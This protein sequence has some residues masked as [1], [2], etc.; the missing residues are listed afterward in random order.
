MKTEELRELLERATKKL[1]YPCT[2]DEAWNDRMKAQV[3]LNAIA[4]TLAADLIRCRELLKD[5]K[6]LVDYEGRSLS[7][8]AEQ[9][10]AETE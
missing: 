6:R 3:E 4:D 10:L 9:Y 5:E 7:D 1:E 8:A 2:L